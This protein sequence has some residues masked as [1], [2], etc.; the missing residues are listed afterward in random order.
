[1]IVLAQ[2]FVEDEE[3]FPSC[4]RLPRSPKEGVPEKSEGIFQAKNADGAERER[5]QQVRRRGGAVAQTY[6]LTSDPRALIGILFFFTALSAGKSR[7][8][9]E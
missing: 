9:T 6:R 3:C 7:R 5:Q 1:M 2:K 8:R 4:Y